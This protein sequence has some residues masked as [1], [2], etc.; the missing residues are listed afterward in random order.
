MAHADELL[1]HHLDPVLGE[2]RWETSEWMGHVRFGPHKVRLLIDLDEEDHSREHQLESIAY[3]KALLP[4]VLENEARLRRQAAEEI[5][6]A[7]G[8]E[9]SAEDRRRYA[10]EAEPAAAALAPQLLCIGFPEGGYLECRD[11]SR[12]FYGAATVVIRFDDG[13]DYEEAEV[14]FE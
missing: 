11:A 14:D 5:A 10:S 9:A 6:Q 3:A 2:L 1:T 4:K 13:G 12:A 8:S 7:A